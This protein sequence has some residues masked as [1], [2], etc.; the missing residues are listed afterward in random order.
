M[1]KFHRLH[2]TE[3]LEDV[4]KTI[5]GEILQIL[6]GGANH[7]YLIEKV[8][9]GSTKSLGAPEKSDRSCGDNALVRV[10]VRSRTRKNKNHD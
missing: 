6:D 4:V 1:Y 7:W 3:K 8:N 5:Q 10:P 2:G 9:D